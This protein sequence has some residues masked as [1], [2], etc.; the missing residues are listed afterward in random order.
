MGN[1]H[2]KRHKKKALDRERANSISNLWRGKPRDYDHLLKVVLIGDAGVG[3]TS[4]LLRFTDNTFNTQNSILSVDFKTRTVVLPNTQQR[5]CKYQI[6]DTAGQERFR[7]ITSSFYRGA[8]LI[9]VV[10]DLTNRQSFNNVY[11]WVEEVDRY[12]NEDAYCVL[13]G[14]K[15][16][17]RLAR[18]VD[19]PALEDVVRMIPRVTHYVETSACTGDNVD[20][21]FTQAAVVLLKAREENW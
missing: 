11:R 17:L 15:S 12:A 4:I 16:D 19:A 20:A 3:K 8:H 14:N 9:F 1:C 5:L 18:A 13:V 10:F 7:T 21:L 6:W 2:R